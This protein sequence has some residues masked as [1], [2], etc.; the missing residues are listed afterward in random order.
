[1]FAM[2]HSIQKKKKKQYI[3]DVKIVLKLKRITKYSYVK[4]FRIH[5]SS[6]QWQSVNIGRLT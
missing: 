3:Y 5:V 4:T 2:T 1:M 6:A